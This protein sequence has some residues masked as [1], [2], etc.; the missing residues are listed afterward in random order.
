MKTF[1]FA[2][3]FTTVVSLLVKLLYLGTGALPTNTRGGLAL[4]VFE[5]AAWISWALWLLAQ[6]A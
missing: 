6:G 1:V 5:N 4:S 2:I 3:L